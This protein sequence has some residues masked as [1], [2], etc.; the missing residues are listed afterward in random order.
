MTSTLKLL[1]KN[2]DQ[3]VHKSVNL[4][5][6]QM[7]SYTHI[8]PVSDVRACDSMKLTLYGFQDLEKLKKKTVLTNLK[9]H[10]CTTVFN[11]IL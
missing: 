8:K 10:T 6:I 4:T 5:A 9:C 1:R 3:E 2:N 11:N 7:C